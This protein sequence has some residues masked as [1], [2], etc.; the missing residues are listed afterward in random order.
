ML[1]Q[2]VETRPGKT[3]LVPR[4]RALLDGR[5]GYLNQGA[6]IIVPDPDCVLTYNYIGWGPFYVVLSVFLV[7]L[8]CAKVGTPPRGS[9]RADLSWQWPGPVKPTG[10]VVAVVTSSPGDSAH[11]LA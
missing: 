4:D 5:Q 1:G 7:N 8:D 2:G 10:N 11:R 6:F 3:I 9:G